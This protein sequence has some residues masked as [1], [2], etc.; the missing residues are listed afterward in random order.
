M[1]AQ[2]SRTSVCH[3]GQRG[4]KSGTGTEEVRV[5]TWGTVLDKGDATVETGR[6]R[7]EVGGEEEM[8]SQDISSP[9]SQ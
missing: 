4:A 3:G 5:G 6:G 9:A 7:E 1:S 8:M 2:E